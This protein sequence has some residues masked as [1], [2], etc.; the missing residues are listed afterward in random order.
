MNRGNNAGGP[1]GLTWTHADKMNSELV[2]FLR[3]RYVTTNETLQ[4]PE[5]FL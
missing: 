4:S 3:L 5:R 1:H 2:A